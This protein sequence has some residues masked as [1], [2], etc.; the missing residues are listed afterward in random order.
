M[1]FS[2]DFKNRLCVIYGDDFQNLLVIDIVSLK[3]E[4]PRPRL[5]LASLYKITTYM[6]YMDTLK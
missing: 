5:A 1:Y 6:I 4:P 3:L 2:E